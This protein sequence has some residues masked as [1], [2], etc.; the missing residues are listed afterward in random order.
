MIDV[1]WPPEFVN[2]VSIFNVVNI[3]IFSLVGVSCV[4]SLNFY[5]SF[6]GMA[7]VPVIIVLVAGLSY[8][9]HKKIMVS[10]LNHMSE[11]HKKVQEVEALHMLYHVSD[12]DGEG[13]IDNIELSTLLN[14]L[15]WAT[16]PTTAYYVM[17]HFHD[18]GSKSWTND[19]GQLVL[20][21]DEFGK[22]SFV[23]FCVILYF[24]HFQC[25]LKKLIIILFLF[26]PR[27]F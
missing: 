2:F 12:L 25:M 7:V 3:D 21:E 16:T 24:L 17:Q 6:V 8:L 9:Q 19:T 10:K 20:T 23:S 5:L 14:Q 1:P 15:G 13:S 4:G 27:F 22:F 26:F 11:E 18:D